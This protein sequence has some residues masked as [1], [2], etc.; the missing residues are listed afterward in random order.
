MDVH[1]GGP[2]TGSEFIVSLPIDTTAQ[3]EPVAL[4]A[5]P[6]PRTSKGLRILVADDYDDAREM[7][8]FLLT[9][10]GH[11]VVTAADGTS[12]LASVIEFKP[13]V[14]ILD[15]GMPGMSGYDVARALQSQ[16]GPPV[17][18]V[19][20][21]G[22]GQNQDRAHAA[23]AGF[24]HHFTKPLDVNALLTFLSTISRDRDGLSRVL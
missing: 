1:S 12:A 14:A 16:D 11:E 23:T 13:D 18:L 4:P 10:E 7:L 6:S 21:S 20:L 3:P 9:K 2:G 22:L 8:S 15:I 5:R 19:A 17:V 24:H